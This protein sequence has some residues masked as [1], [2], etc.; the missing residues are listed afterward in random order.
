MKGGYKTV[1]NTNSENDFTFKP[2]TVTPIFIETRDITLP[3]SNG[4]YDGKKL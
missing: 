1:L 2:K 4:F 3:E